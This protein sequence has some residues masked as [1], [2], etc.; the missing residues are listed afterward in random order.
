MHRTLI[1]FGT[2]GIRSYGVMLAI[3]FWV[4]IELSAR[5]ARKKGLNENLIIDLGLVVLVAA[6]AG[7]RALFV[8][9]HLSEFKGDWLGVV[10][11]WEGG[12]TFY[13][14]LIAATVAGITMLKAKGQPVLDV[15]DIVAPQIALGI[16]IARIGCFLNGCCFGK[17]SSLP[18]A[19]QFPPDCQA[20]SVM[21]GTRIHPTQLYSTV[22]NFLIF[23][24]LTRIVKR[25]ETHGEVFFTFLF[26]YGMW[27][28]FIDY[29]RYY[30]SGMYLRI[31]SLV[32]TWNQVVSMG[33]AAVGLVLLVTVTRGVK[34]G[35]GGESS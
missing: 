28:F 30:E 5:L 10:R 14:G 24:L 35:F 26:V 21:Y 3:A 27:R 20:G 17:P 31:G 7:S 33:L 12:L 8:L 22:A 16:A 23:V 13:G 29:L 1:D 18:W 19:C 6:I 25:T 11:V 34:G 32:V 9:E 2:L 15:T 4:G